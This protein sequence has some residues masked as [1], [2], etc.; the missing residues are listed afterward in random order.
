MYILKDNQVLG[1]YFGGYEPVIFE[2]LEE[3]EEVLREL[4]EIKKGP[5]KENLKEEGK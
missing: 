5:E 2:T 1:R 4:I 3:V